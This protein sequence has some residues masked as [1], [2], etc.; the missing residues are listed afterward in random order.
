[1]T[2]TV[3]EGVGR[4]DVLQRLFESDAVQVDGVLRRIAK[5]AGEG[6]V[7][8]GGIGD[9]LQQVAD[10]AGEVQIERLARRR[11]QRRLRRH[12]PRPF[13]H[14]VDFRTGPARLD[15]IKDLAIELRRLRGKLPVG[16]VVFAGA[17]V[18]AHRR[19]ELSLLFEVLAGGRMDHRGFEH[20]ALERDPVLG[21]VG[22]VL[23]G[24]PVVRDGRVPVV[25]L[26]GVETLAVR[27]RCSAAAERGGNDHQYSKPEDGSGHES[28][29]RY[30]PERRIT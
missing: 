9:E 25:A 18:L 15:G 20:R 4:Q 28:A 2:S 27:N 5:V 30:D 3:E 24:L 26:A 29:L 6:D 13:T 1:M 16:R 11:I 14:L 17:L 7:D 12:P 23:D 10:A 19:V 8:A 22:I 21:P